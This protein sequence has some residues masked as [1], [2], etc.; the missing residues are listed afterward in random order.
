MDEFL[1][2]CGFED[3]EIEEKKPR[4]ERAFEILEIRP[5][6]LE[7]GKSRISSYFDIDLDGIRKTLGM[8]I[9]EATDL[10]LAKQDGKKIVYVSYPALPEISATVATIPGFF[11]APPE[12]IIDTTMGHIFDKINPILETGER[13][14]LP[15]GYA[16]CSLLQAR[17]GSIESGISPIPD[18]TLCSSFLCDQAPKTDELLL[19]E[20]HGVPVA[21]LDACVDDDWKRWPN[22]APRRLEYFE[23]VLKDA[24]ETFAQVTD[25]SITEQM[26]AAGIERYTGLLKSRMELNK[27]MRADPIPLSSVD[28]GIVNWLVRSCLRTGLEEGPEV[29]EILINEVKQRVAEGKGVVEKGAPR[30]ALSYHPTTDPGLE[31]MIEEAGLA[32]SATTHSS[33]K[34]PSFF[35]PEGGYP[36]Y[37]QEIGASGLGRGTRHSDIAMAHEHLELA[38]QW[39]VDG[40]IL[41]FMFS[42][43]GVCIYAPMAKKLL[44]NEGIPTILLE[45]DLYDTRNYTPESMRTKIETFAEV[46]RMNKAAKA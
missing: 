35:E 10:V 20:K 19:H 22:A 31:K 44:D 36:S 3:K 46:L 9:K 40:V 13:S 39:N 45:H 29:M 1:K 11:C 26:L 38:K 24:F 33:V 41:T 14:G 15:P 8:W 23:A 37:Y 6:D 30:V 7:R 2:L 32:I 21:Y 28:M 17:V 4:I 25:Q 42:C 12:I 5:D 16:N 27:L 43:R 18:L 34:V